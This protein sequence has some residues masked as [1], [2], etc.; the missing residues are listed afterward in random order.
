M[1][2]KA[3][4]FDLDDT[5]TDTHGQL[6][7]KAHQD[8]CRSMQAAGLDVPLAEMFERR[9]ALARSRPR[10]DVNQ[11]LAEHYGYTD[12]RIH[13]AGYR[14]FYRP[15]VQGIK[16]FPDA[17]AVLQGLQQGYQL[18]LVTAGVQATQ[19]AKIQ[20]L[21]LGPY[22][23]QCYFVDFE[24]PDCPSSK[25]E[26]FG[27]IQTQWGWDSLEMVVIGDRLDNEI[28][29]ARQLGLWSIRMCHGEYAALTPQTPLE[30][31]HFTIQALAELPDILKT[32]EQHACQE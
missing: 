10:E 21:G 1:A 13:R 22:F 14:T 17:H 18:L 19:Q 9:L 29:A 26:A 32:I 16:P 12:K 27:Q 5:L 11:L 7:L 23:E 6:V 8:A 25:G 15:N 20:E 2:L 3:L 31:P 28:A 4:I 30:T 24:H